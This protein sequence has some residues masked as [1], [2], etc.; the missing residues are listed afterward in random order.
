MGENMLEFTL[1]VI[2]IVAVVIVAIVFREKL[3]QPI[4]EDARDRDGTL[5]MF[6]VAGVLV[7]L[8]WSFASQLSNEVLAGIAI[9][10]SNAFT[11]IVAFHYK[12]K[13]NG[14]H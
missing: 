5:V 1:K 10:Q 13:E 4:F 3:R 11:M 14:K 2:L 7:W 6:M 9:G 8:L 12:N